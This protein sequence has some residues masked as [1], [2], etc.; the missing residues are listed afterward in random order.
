MSKDIIKT[1]HYSI[2]CPRCGCHFTFESED[3]MAKNPNFNDKD[4]VSCPYCSDEIQARNRDTH[5]LLPNVKIDY[6]GGKLNKKMVTV[7][8]WSFPEERFESVSFWSQERDDEFKMEYVFEIHI[9][10]EKP[11]TINTVDRKMARLWAT[12][13]N[14]DLEAWEQEIQEARV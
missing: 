11:T 9:K 7:A 8:D 10:D 13:L 6:T 2:R 14:I 1:P 5:A 4:Y 3:F 12:Q